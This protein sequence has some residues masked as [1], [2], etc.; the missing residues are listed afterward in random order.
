[1]ECINGGYITALLR[2]RLSS[3]IVDDTDARFAMSSK[4]R[5]LLTIAV[6]LLNV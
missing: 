2:L 3:F 6:F 1:M 4:S 5:T